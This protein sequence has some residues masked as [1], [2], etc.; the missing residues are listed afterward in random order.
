[1][2]SG[3]NG[4]N[5]LDGDARPD[6]IE[7]LGGDDTPLDGL[8]DDALMGGPSDERVIG[9]GHNETLI[10]GTGK[11]FLAGGNNTDMYIFDFG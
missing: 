6:V 11:G 8:G 4:N 2:T 3:I 1:M 7:G 9:G 10:G 5:L